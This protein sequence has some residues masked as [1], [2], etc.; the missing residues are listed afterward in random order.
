MIKSEINLATDGQFHTCHSQMER[1]HTQSGVTT[2]GLIG[3]RPLSLDIMLL[4]RGKVRRLPIDTWR[5]IM[6]MDWEIHFT[7]TRTAPLLS[8]AEDSDPVFVETGY[9]STLQDARD[10]AHRYRTLA[11]VAAIW[12]LV[13]IITYTILNNIL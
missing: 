1:L 7:R 3:E 13:A 6:S 9:E 11:I 8:R 12:P 2:V 5:Q 10:K 4:Y